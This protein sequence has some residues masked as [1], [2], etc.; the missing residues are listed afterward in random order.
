MMMTTTTTTMIIIIL[1]IVQA[2]S[3]D[4]LT[5]LRLIFEKF[6]NGYR[7]NAERET[8]ALRTEA[9]ILTGPFLNTSP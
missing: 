1:L 3:I 4:N 5:W 9:H 8:T 7:C 6:R 2:E